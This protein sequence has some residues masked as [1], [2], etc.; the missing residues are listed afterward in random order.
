MLKL[1][2]PTH[3]LNGLKGFRQ[4]GSSLDDIIPQRASWI[5]DVQSR[6]GSDETDEPIV[7]TTDGHQG[8]III[9]WIKCRSTIKA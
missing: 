9:K 7:A 6:L 5:H 3:L 4:I 1:S 2:Y 8:L